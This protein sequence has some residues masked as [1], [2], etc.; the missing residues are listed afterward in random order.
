MRMAVPTVRLLII[1]TLAFAIVSSTCANSLVVP[2]V[3]QCSRPV[4]R[5]VR[6][7]TIAAS[8]TTVS[9]VVGTVA[10]L[11]AAIL[12]DGG[13]PAYKDVTRSIGPVPTTAELIPRRIKV[14]WLQVTIR[15]TAVI[16]SG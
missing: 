5:T 3:S 4:G 10:N 15:T 9:T 14:A 12:Q 11:A 16:S 7:L 2:H 1:I 8:P 13:Q 6:W